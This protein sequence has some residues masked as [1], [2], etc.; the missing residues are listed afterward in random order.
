MRGCLGCGQKPAQTGPFTLRNSSSP[1]HSAGQGMISGRG[2]HRGK[3]QNVAELKKGTAAW[4]VYRKLH[5]KTYPHLANANLSE[6]NLRRPDL[7]EANLIQADLPGADLR[8][9]DLSG[10]YL[11][12]ARLVRAD[13]RGANLGM[14]DLSHV[15]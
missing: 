10:A 7:S 4:N 6:A 15:D 14:A 2:W 9:V 12:S 1:T 8:V 11:G 5:P 3:Q 13:L